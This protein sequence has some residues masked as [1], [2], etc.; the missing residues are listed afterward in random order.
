MGWLAM[1]G[2]VVSGGGGGGGCEGVAGC[3]GEGVSSFSL[4][5]VYASIMS[6]VPCGK[7]YGL[8]QSAMA[9]K[10][11]EPLQ[12]PGSCTQLCM[13]LLVCRMMIDVC[14]ANWR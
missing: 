10:A 5:A 6:P 3:E 9:T 11:N 8:Q 1:E 13:Q 12:G 4:G 14:A 2:R 7:R